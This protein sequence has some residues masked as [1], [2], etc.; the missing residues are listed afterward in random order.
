[1][2]QDY[3]RINPVTMNKALKQWLDLLAEKE[4]AFRKNTMLKDELKDAVNLIKNTE[5]KSM[6]ENLK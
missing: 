4:T 1:M 3:D 5:L 2:P 6:S